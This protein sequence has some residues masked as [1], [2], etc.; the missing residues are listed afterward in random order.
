MI[1]TI[2]ISSI[3]YIQ[4]NSLEPPSTRCLTRGL[5]ACGGG[6]IGKENI[7]RRSLLFELDLDKV[8]LDL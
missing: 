4:P 5:A 1:V 7:R 2:T 3:I 8:L 6:A